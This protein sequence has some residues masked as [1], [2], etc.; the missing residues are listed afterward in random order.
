MTDLAGFF[1]GIA[2]AGLWILIPMEVGRF[3]D[4]LRSR[5]MSKHQ[6]KGVE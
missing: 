4:W 2:L 5:R 1:F 6:P 3:F